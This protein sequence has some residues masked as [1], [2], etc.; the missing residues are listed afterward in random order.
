M[1]QTL[2]KRIKKITEDCDDYDL[3]FFSDNLDEVKKQFNSYNFHLLNN[4]NEIEDL[5][6]IS[7]CNSVIMSNSTF[8]WWGAWLGKKKEKIIFPKPWFGIMGPQDIQDICPNHW[9]EL[10]Y[11]KTN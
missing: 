3:I 8:S 10:S 9:M 1:L 7:Q 4:Q 2:L 6:A 11:E 5:Y